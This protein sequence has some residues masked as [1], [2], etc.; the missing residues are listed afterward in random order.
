M[1]A[2]EWTI[3]INKWNNGTY[4]CRSLSLKALNTFS[5]S[6]CVKYFQQFDNIKDGDGQ[7]RKLLK[8][9]FD[10]TPTDQAGPAGFSPTVVA[11]R[12]GMISPQYTILSR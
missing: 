9:N 3:Y 2:D 8:L 12:D 4:G 7:L 11:A 6:F 10:R 5:G 1:A